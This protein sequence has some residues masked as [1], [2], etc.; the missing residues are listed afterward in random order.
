[1]A[2]NFGEDTL[3]IGSHPE[4]DDFPYFNNYFES[5]KKLIEERIKNLST[6]VFPSIEHMPYIINNM[7]NVISPV[8]IIFCPQLLYRFDQNQIKNLESIFQISS[9]NRNIKSPYCIAFDDNDF[10]KYNFISNYFQDKNLANTHRRDGESS[11]EIW[12]KNRDRIRKFG[13]EKGIKNLRDAIYAFIKE[14]LNKA[15]VGTFRP[16]L[17]AGF[18]NVF[19]KKLLN[20]PC[21]VLDIC[22][23]WGDRMIGFVAS[24]ADVYVGVDPNPDLFE[25]YEK[26]LNFVKE[27]TSSKTDVQMI[28][29]PFETAEIPDKKYNLIFTSPPY[30]D[31]EIYSDKDGQSL[32]TAEI[33][34]TKERSNTFENWFEDFLMTSLLKAW[35]FLQPGGWMCINI[36]NY[37]D[38][39]ESENKDSKGEKQ[40]KFGPDFTM[41]MVYEVNRRIGG[42]NGSAIYC[43]PLSF[44]EVFELPAAVK[45]NIKFK[46]NRKMIRSP[47]PIWIWRKAYEIQNGIKVEITA[48]KELLDTMEGNKTTAKAIAGTVCTKGVEIVYEPQKMHELLL[49]KDFLVLRGLGT[50]FRLK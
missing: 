32:K 44:G 3:S 6:Y 38:F 39:I 12:N 47:Q 16:S 28:N 5:D 40:R 13:E 9:E 34:T 49:R 42:C 45:N 14:E 48:D 24:S 29:S 27:V 17:A 46:K 11:V 50:R 19:F 1:M 7:R 18:N 4:S 10:L 2:L 35:K 30:F 8:D 25:G 22:S 37:I 33:K 21:R 23:G 20:E 31:L 36:N 26:S 15:E 43:G 41:R